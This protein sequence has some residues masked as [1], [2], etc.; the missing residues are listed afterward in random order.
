MNASARG[1]SASA[2]STRSA[3]ASAHAGDTA[4]VSLPLT[5]RRSLR[6]CDEAPGLAREAGL[7]PR[8]LVAGADHGL[9]VEALDRE[10]GEAARGC[11]IGEL[12][13][14]LGE[15]VVGELGEPQHP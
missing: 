1:G 11:G 13:E 3:N 2:S 10:L 14:R 6:R 12:A 5:P 8:R 15:L 9:A 7:D 4:W